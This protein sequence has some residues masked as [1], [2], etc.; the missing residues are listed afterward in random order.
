MSC[1]GFINVTN[2]FSLYGSIAISNA[3]PGT[4]TPKPVNAKCLNLHPATIIIIQTIPIITID[5][6]KCGSNNNNPIIG[7]RYNMCFTKP[8][9]YKGNSSLSFTNIPA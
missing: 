6:L 1:H 7:T 4:P 2:L 9:Q 3:S 5:A 8:F